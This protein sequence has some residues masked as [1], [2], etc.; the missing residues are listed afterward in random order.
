MARTTTRDLYILIVVGGGLV[1]SVLMAFGAVLMSAA[2]SAANNEVLNLVEG[3][4]FFVVGAA[5][6]IVSLILVPAR[7]LLALEGGQKS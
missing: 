2:Y 4:A 3:T 1:G 5:F 6:V 7:R